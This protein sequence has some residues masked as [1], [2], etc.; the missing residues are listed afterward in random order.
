MNYIQEVED[1]LEEI[2]KLR[3]TPYEGLLGVYSLLTL[4][5]GTKCSNEDVHNAWSVWQNKVFP[6]HPSLK[7]FDELSKEVQNLDDLY[8]RA[9]IEVAWELGK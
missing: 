9:I 2:L 5:V 3:D 8:R 6:T 4:T 1:K 7:P